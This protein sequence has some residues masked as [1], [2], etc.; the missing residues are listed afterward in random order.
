VKILKAIRY[1][2]LTPF[3]HQTEQGR[4]DERYR[5]AALSI[6]ANVLNRVFAIFL[7]IL[8]VSLTLPYLGAERFGIWMTIA[9]FAAILTFLDLGVGNALTNQVAQRAALGDESLLRRTISGGLGFLAVIGLCMGVVLWFFAANLPWEKIIKVTDKN[10]IPEVRAAAICFAVLFGFNIFSSGVVRVYVGLQ[11]GF[12]AYL[13]T[14]LVTFF[15][16]VATW[17][18][19]EAEQGIVVLL[20]IV[21]GSQ[22]LAGLILLYMLAMQKLME[23]KDILLEIVN[24]SSHLLKTGGLFFILQ[25]GTMIGWGAD[26]LIIANTLG[27]AHVAIFSVVQRL[28]QFSTQPL[29]ILNAPLWP[30][31]ADAHARGDKTFIRNTL[32]KSILITF[33]SSAVGAFTLLLVHTWFVDKWTH[34]MIIAPFGFVALYAVW[35]ILEACGNAFS[36]FLNGTNVVKIQVIAVTGFIL[37]SLPIKL[38]IIKHVGLMTIPGATAISYLIAVVG[39]YVLFYKKTFQDQS[40]IKNELVG[41]KNNL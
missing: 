28:F 9:S 5:V 22:T 10:L 13:V 34:G 36:M 26:S 35:S 39:I 41:E 14:A 4:T 40:R 32:R 21:L 29:S 30:A 16:C 33:Y 31:Y 25:I 1:V 3:D 7:T 8:G 38:V 2:R 11:Q 24:E 23:F 12:K 18:A 37:L 20:A 27:A 17:F 6:L 19:A 15:A